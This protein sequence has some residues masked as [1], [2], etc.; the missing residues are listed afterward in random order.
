[1]LDALQ[2]T[3]RKKSIVSF[4]ITLAI[5][6]GIFFNSIHHDTFIGY[7]P[8]NIKGCTTHLASLPCAP[9]GWSFLLAVGVFF[10]FKFLRRY[11]DTQEALL[12]HSPSSFGAN[13]INYLQL[14]NPFN[15]LLRRG[16]ICQLVYN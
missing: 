3:F 1:M 11:M 6:F 8:E 15:R 5:I 10:A 12:F 13:N 2:I 9:A 4:V 16:I 7:H 14:F